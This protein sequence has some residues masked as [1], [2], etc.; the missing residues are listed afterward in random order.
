[1]DEISLQ[2]LGLVSK[3]LRTLVLSDNPVVETTDHRLSVLILV[4]Q[5]ERVDKVPVSPEERIEARDKIK[6]KREII[7]FLFVAWS[8]NPQN[9]QFVCWGF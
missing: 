1:M 8:K 4:P 7:L 9:N 6:V 3:T 2:Y 5:L